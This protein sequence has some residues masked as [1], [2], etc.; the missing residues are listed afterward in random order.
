LLAGREVS[1]KLFGLKAWDPVSLGVSALL[2]TIV[3]LLTSLVPA[4]KAAHV[5][6]IS[7]LRVE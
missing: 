6:P 1:S 7:S 5:D 4:L 3:T 2:L